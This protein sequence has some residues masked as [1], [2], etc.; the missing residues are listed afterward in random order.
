MKEPKVNPRALA[1]YFRKFA[2]LI[3]AGVPLIRAM[4]TVGE[5]TGDPH[6]KSINAAMMGGIEAG[7]TLSVQMGRLPGVFSRVALVMVRAGEVGGILDE[8]LQRLAQY[9]DTDIELRERCRF[10]AT[11]AG[12]C[13]PA[14]ADAMQRRLKAA[15]DAEGSRVNEAIFCR[16]LGAMIGAGVPVSL[17]LECAAD[18]FEGQTGADLKAAA[19]ELTGDT[20]LADALGATGALSS[21]T[22]ELCRVGEDV[23]QLDFVLKHAAD[24]QE[25]ETMSALCAALTPAEP[26]GDTGARAV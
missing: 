23:G 1:L 9:L 14:A 21:V 5:S 13:D 2:T 6:L 4:D 19:R 24:L 22:L 8:T 7:D 18:A 15:L 11:L 12:L 3:G 25:T 16:A 10:Y 20:A 17:A 26:T